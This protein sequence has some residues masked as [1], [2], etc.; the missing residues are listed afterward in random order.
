M[1]I[2]HA[3]FSNDLY[4]FEQAFPGV[5]DCTSAAM[6]AAIGEWFGLYFGAEVDKE[7]PCQQLPYTVVSKLCRTAFAEYELAVTGGKESFFTGAVLPWLDEARKRAV[8]LALIGGEAWLKPVPLNAEKRFAFLPMRRDC[9][10][11]IARAPG[12]EVTDLVS[13]ETTKEGGKVYTLL[14]RRRASARGA[15]IDSKLFCSADGASLGS[16]MPL[17]TLAKYASLLPTNTLPGVEGIG[18]ARLA[19]PMENCVDGSSDPVS[20]Y[21][22][23]VGLIHNVNKNEW[24]LGREFEKGASRIIASADMMTKDKNGKARLDDELF[25]G[26]DDDPEAVGITIFSP[27]LREQS[28]LAR[29][30]EYLRNLETV[31]GIKRGLLGEVEAAQRTATEVTSSQGDYS[32]TLAD[33]QGMW[34]SCAR[35]ALRL[36]DQ[37]G[38]AYKLCG[39]EP[40]DPQKDVSISWGNGILY[41]KDKDWAET[42]ALVSAGMLRPEIALAWRYDLPWKTPKDLE[43][44]RALYMPEL[45]QMA[46]DE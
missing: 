22:A 31:M 8:Q 18:L 16:Q 10:V 28:F 33:V 13:A 43:K 37:L 3:M 26:I 27:A 20:V 14:E 34:E 36:C 46:G 2:L 44:V 17:A 5:R 9:V 32:L 40:F 1:G 24:Q 6:K 4:S 15:V 39:A 38:R 19:V 29:K 42:M 41:D 7:D 12:G 11:V 23:A 45:E 25:A 30:A 35:Q 21:A